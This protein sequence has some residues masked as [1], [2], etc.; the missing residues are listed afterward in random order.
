[1]ADTT[2]LATGLDTQTPSNETQTMRKE[3][4]DAIKELRQ[5]VQALYD[6]DNTY[7]TVDHDFDAITGTADGELALDAIGLVANGYYTTRDIPVVGRVIYTS[8]T[9]E[10]ITDIT[11]GQAGQLLVVYSSSTGTL[12]FTSAAAKIKGITEGDIVLE[13]YDSAFL[14]CLDGTIWVELVTM[15]AVT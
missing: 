12:T 9:N 8:A 6:R 13:Q 15:N 14:Y 11:G 3:H 4:G 2:T 7:V 1:M 5:V 10:T